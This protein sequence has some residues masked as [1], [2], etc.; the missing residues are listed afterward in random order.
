M[1]GVWLG[2]V[3]ALVWGLMGSGA[4]FAV[5]A[6]SVEV[7]NVKTIGNAKAPKGGTVYF[8]MDAEPET[9]N[10]LRE[11]DAWAHKIHEFTMEGL[12]VLNQDT[13]KWMPGIAERFEASKD[14]LSYTFYLRKDVK[15]HDGSLLTANDV[16]FTIDLVKD[17]AYG[18]IHKQPYYDKVKKV[19]VIDEY[20]VKISFT[21]K[22]FNNFN[23]VV[24]D[25]YQSLVSKKTYGDPKN[26]LNKEL[27][28]TGPYKLTRYTKGKSIELEKNKEWWGWSVP[29]LQ[30]MFN[31]EK[32][33]FRFV[34]DNNLALNMME[35]GL[36]DLLYPVPVEDFYKKT[37]NPPWGKEIIKK[38]VINKKPKGYGFVGWNLLDEKFKDRN[39]RVAL[40]HLMN[41]ELINQKFRYGKSELA[42]GPWSRDSMYAD[43][44]VEPIEFNSERA[45]QILDKAGWVDSN[46][47]GV[48][49]KLIN[50]K[51]VDFQFTLLLVNRDVEK[52]FTIY[53]EDLKKAGIHMNLRIVEW[54]TFV[55]SL[56]GKDFEAVAL[57]WAG[58]GVHKDPKQVWHSEASKEGGSNFISYK[59]PEVDKLIDRGRSILNNKERAKVFKQVYRLI[60]KDAPYLFMFYDKYERYARNKR[61]G[62]AKD[63]YNY[64]IGYQYWWL[65]D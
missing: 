46:K 50:N 15:F 34:K 13:Y 65:T 48:R 37:N 62:V 45:R 49:D 14:G 59:N 36:L 52:Y 53:K 30:G 22:Y 19:E 12:M 24:S 17:P 28:G 42:T 8:Q 23:V 60:A 4:A 44:S 9:L 39:V 35:K 25:G 63:S 47:D 58:G 38:E 18:A 57:G 61:I 64:D 16:K 33:V 11:A 41:R 51:R 26:K 32:I 21:E 10:P 31:Y 1:K 5:D 2:L 3:S 7:G 29:H 27:V 6:D 20:T 55:K 56:N 54:N 40:A 43:S